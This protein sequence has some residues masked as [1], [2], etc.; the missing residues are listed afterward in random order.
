MP[1]RPRKKDKDGI[2]M[3]SGDSGNVYDFPEGSEHK[4][5]MVKSKSMMDYDER[6]S[7]SGVGRRSSSKKT[8]TDFTDSGVSVVSDTPP[9]VHD[10]PKDQSRV[11]TWLR[12]SDRSARSVGYTHSE[13][14]IKQHR[15][16]R[17][18]SATS[19][20]ASRSVLFTK[21][22]RLHANKCEHDH[23]ENTHISKRIKIVMIVLEFTV[24]PLYNVTQ[25][26][27]NNVVKLKIR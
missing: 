9:V 24:E 23:L 8:L 17:T 12:E 25:A 11:L 18:S 27:Y 6:F 22:K 20:N 2:S 10:L 3:F 4:L 14:S 1:V 13:M 26:S 5:A 7:R 15:G 16:H 21:K 19:P